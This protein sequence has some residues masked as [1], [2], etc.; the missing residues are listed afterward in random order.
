LGFLA[1]CCDKVLSSSAK[2]LDDLGANM[3]DAGICS[4]STGACN[5]RD[6]VRSQ[7]HVEAYNSNMYGI[8][9]LQ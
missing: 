2:D 8:V 9:L 6:R 1:E 4:S 5:H 7:R 3:F